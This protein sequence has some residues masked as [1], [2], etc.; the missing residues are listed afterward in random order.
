MRLSGF[1]VRGCAGCLLGD[2]SHTMVINL[3][4]HV[5]SMVQTLGS[6]ILCSPFMGYPVWYSGSVL[7]SHYGGAILS[8][9]ILNVVHQRLLSVREIFSRKG[10]SFEI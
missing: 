5:G 3:L 10:Q 1:S 4:G 8:F 7:G 9:V 2:P 6:Y